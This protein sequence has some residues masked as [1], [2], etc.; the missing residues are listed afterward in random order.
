MKPEDT[1][2]TEYVEFCFFCGNPYKIEGHHFVCGEGRRENGTDDG[3]LL[4]LCRDCHK[5]AHS[6][7]MVMFFSKL[8]GQAFWEMIRTDQE[9]SN[10]M[11]QEDLE[12]FKE[13]RRKEF[14][15]RYYQSFF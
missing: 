11:D 4:P 12:V 14:R 2:I 13:Q 8:A 7:G 10:Y 3:L 1:K 15:G 6:D 5:R 9:L